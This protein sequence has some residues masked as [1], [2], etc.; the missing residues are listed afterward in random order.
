M[1]ERH[2]VANKQLFAYDAGTPAG[3]RLEHGAPCG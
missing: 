1:E 3:A 2:T